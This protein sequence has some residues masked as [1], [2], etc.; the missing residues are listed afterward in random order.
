[1][2]AAAREAAY[3]ALRAVSTGVAD[4]PHALA[5]VRTRLP[6]ERDRALTGEIVTGTLRWQGAFDHVISVF[7]GRP[8]ARLDP[9]VVDVLRISI[10]QL[11]YL[12]RVPAAAV[13]SDAVN[14]TRKIGKKSAGAFPAI[15]TTTSISGSP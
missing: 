15:S 8:L 9:E 14:L 7:S 5:R 10:F 1:M 3:Q 13:V 6:D 2:I 11:L 12:E 4:L